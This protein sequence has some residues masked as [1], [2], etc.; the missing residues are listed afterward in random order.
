M[1]ILFKV[2]FTSLVFFSIIS[3]QGSDGL[4]V[5]KDKIKLRIIAEGS[6]DLISRSSLENT[7]KLQ[8]RRNNIEYFRTNDEAVPDYP[9]YLY[10]NLNASKLKNG[11]VYG[12]IELLFKR[13]S[14]IYVTVDERFDKSFKLRD[15]IFMPGKGPFFGATTWSVAERFYIPSRYNYEQII[16]NSITDFVDEFSALYID[17]NN[18]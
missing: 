7:I 14:L 15:I 12:N 1:K 6:S 3:A 13:S 17:A 5:P 4:E 8:L 2:I 9:H 18:L 11:D 10:L 16:K